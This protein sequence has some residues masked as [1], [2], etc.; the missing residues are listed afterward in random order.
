MKST[1]LLLALFFVAPLGMAQDT[2]AVT[3]EPAPEADEKI[4]VADDLVT[5]LA[6]ADQF[7]VL[8][9]ALRDTGLDQALSG[10]ETFTVFAP[11]DAAF[12]SLPEGTL[13]ALTPD[14]LTRI[15]RYHV[16]M[17]SVTAA[18]AAELASATTVEGSA[19]TITPEGDALMI[20]GAT[21]TEAD[22]EV[23][24][25]VIHVI[26]TVLMPAESIEGEAAGG[27]APEEDTESDYTDDDI[28]QDDDVD[29]KED[30]TE[31]ATSEASPEST[32]DQR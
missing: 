18:D 6:A 27:T 14:E 32:D 23:S 8:V 1:A 24:N 13:E 19:L 31:D 15:L 25:G 2:P 21:V 17:G 26:D 16:V 10:D 20:D 5:A 4:V 29:Q 7:T 3:P 9:Q 28:E 12:A 30:D 11:T 22:I